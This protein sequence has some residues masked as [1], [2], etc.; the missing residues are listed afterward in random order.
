M[1]FETDD[2]IVETCRGERVIRVIRTSDAVTGEAR[3]P[4]WTVVDEA[5]VLW[6]TVT[7]SPRILRVSPVDDATGAAAFLGPTSVVR[8]GFDGLG[9]LPTATVGGTFG[10]RTL[11]RLSLSRSVVARVGAYVVEVDG[12][13]T[14]LDDDYTSWI[15]GLGRLVAVEATYPS[16]DLALPW[17]YF[18]DGVLEVEVWRGI[19][20]M[21]SARTTDGGFLDAVASSDRMGVA[22]YRDG[23]SP[24]WSVTVPTPTPTLSRFMLDRG[25]RAWHLLQPLEPLETEVRHLAISVEPALGEHWY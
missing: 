18:R 20:V 21:L 23:A 4:F 14:S 3:P 12:T 8:G 24:E 19:D 15:D 22:H 16:F 6:A 7:D 13:I 2:G 1:Y 5:G 17:R 10:G 11:V 25:H 9:E